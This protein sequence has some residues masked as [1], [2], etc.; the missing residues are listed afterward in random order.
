MHKIFIEQPLVPD[1]YPDVF[2]YDYIP[3]MDRAMRK[4]K[5]GFYHSIG[6]NIELNIKYPKQSHKVQG[7]DFGNGNILYRD[8]KIIECCHFICKSRKTFYIAF[9]YPFLDHSNEVYAVYL[10]SIPLTNETEDLITDSKINIFDIYE[11]LEVYADGINGNIGFQE[12]GTGLQ[13]QWLN[14]LH[15]EDMDL[16]RYSYEIDSCK[17]IKGQHQKQKQGERCIDNLIKDNK[18]ERIH[19]HKVNGSDLYVCV[20]EPSGFIT[21]PAPAVTVCLGGPN[22]VIPDFEAEDT[23]YD[24]IAN[25]GFYVIIPLR[26]GVIG[27]NMKWASGLSGNAGI[28][29]VDDVTVGVKSI[30]DIYDGIIDRYRVGLYGASFGGYTSLLIAGK[31]NRNKMFK[32]IISHCGMSDLVNYPYECYGNPS[33]IKRYYAGDSDFDVKSR[34]IS[35]YTYIE[36]WTSPTL[37]V[38]TIDDTCVWFGQSVRTYNKAIECHKDVNLILAN[39]QHSYEIP[40]GDKLVVFIINFLKDK[41]G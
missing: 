35:P 36:N 7:W 1:Q 6:V 5:Y 15:N 41:L 20:I 11:P 12:K 10:Y 25:A 16:S 24:K 3:S 37:L 39:G 29:D 33:D 38:H 28:A 9:T 14:K 17:I 8:K 30:L 19:Y 27:I 40:N 18:S 34:E 4:D 26:R 31:K 23:I 2:A 22:I 21:H 13:L 32:A